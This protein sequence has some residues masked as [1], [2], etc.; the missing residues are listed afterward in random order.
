MYTI[1]IVDDEANI[2]LL[3]EKELRAEGYETLLARDGNEALAKVKQDDIDLVLLD[4]KMPGM[5]GLDLLN[6][7]MNIN[8]QMPVVLNSAYA[9]FKDNFSTWSADAYVVKSSDLG[10]MKATVKE[11]LQSRYEKKS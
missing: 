8:P 3:Y 1:L 7:I 11:V 2:R 5:D 10:E 4:I 9:S 6:R